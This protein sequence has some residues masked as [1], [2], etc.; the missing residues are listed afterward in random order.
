MKSDKNLLIKTPRH[1][2]QINWFQDENGLITLEIKN[3]GIA[4]RIAQILIN[5]PKISFIHL[6][7]FGS[8]IWKIIDSKRNVLTIGQLVKERFGEKAEPVYERLSLYIKTL[9]QNKFITVI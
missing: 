4:N 7:E 9:E 8:F 5:K 2:E 1:N 6:E 3:R